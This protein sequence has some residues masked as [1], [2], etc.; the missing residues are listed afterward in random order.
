MID[1]LNAIVEESEATIARLAAELGEAKRRA[2]A[3][4]ELLTATQRERDAYLSLLVDAEMFEDGDLPE[5]HETGQSPTGRF[6]AIQTEDV[7]V[8]E[9]RVFATYA[10]AVDAIRRDCGLY[11]SESAQE[12]AVRIN[13]EA[14]LTPEDPT[15]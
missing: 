15:P 2:K 11:W 3:T 13:A 10:A 7:E 14:W 12:V 4:I 8:P 6:L 9:H 5:D 1:T